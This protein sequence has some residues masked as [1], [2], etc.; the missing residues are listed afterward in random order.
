M[1]SMITRSTSRALY[2][3]LGRVARVVAAIAAEPQ[4]VPLRSGRVQVCAP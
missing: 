4:P 2:A 1:E 3:E